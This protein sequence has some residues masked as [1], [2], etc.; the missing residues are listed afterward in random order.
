MEIIKSKRKSKCFL[1]QKNITLKYKV[2]NGLVNY[3]LSCY[4]SRY[5]KPNSEYYKKQIKELNKPKYK[6]QMIVENL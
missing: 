2:K 6:K 4:Y 3:H 5:V 1:C